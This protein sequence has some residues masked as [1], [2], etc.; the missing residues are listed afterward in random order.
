MEEQEPYRVLPK[1]ST[2][3]V[4][5]DND[6]TVLTCRDEPSAGHYVALLTQAFRRGYKVGFREAR[7][8]I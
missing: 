8:T 5:D 3:C 2:Y 4:V 1:D 6:R 7:R